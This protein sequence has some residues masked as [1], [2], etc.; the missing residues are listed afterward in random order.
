VFVSCTHLCAA[1][2]WSG[3][4]AT[5]LVL[6]ATAECSPPPAADPTTGNELA[7]DRGRLPTGATLD[8]TGRSTPIG[9]FPL[10][11]IVAPGGDRL[12]ALLN[13]H[14]AQGIQVIDVASGRVT[15]T[16]SQPAAF[17]GLAFDAAGYRLYAS[18]GNQDVVYRY[19]WKAGTATL[20][21]SLVLAP[22]APRASGTRYPAGLALSPDDRFLYVA[23]NLADSLAVID[24]ATGA[25]VQR[26]AAGRYPYAVVVAVDG[27]VYVSAWGGHEVRAFERKGNR[28]VLRATIPAGRHPSA[29][30]LNRDGTRLFVT[31]AS[32]DQIAV[33]DT[34]RATVTAQLSD[35]A[36]TGPAEGSTPDALALSPD[37]GRLYV[38]EADNNAI[39]VF[40]LSGE[41]S[42]LPDHLLGRI[43][44]EW[45]PAAVV[46]HNDTLFV[47]N[48]KGRGTGPNPLGPGPGVR[49]RDSLGYT[50]DQTSGTL[51]VV[52][53]AGLDAAGLGALSRRVAH[54]N[55]WDLRAAG[56]PWPH[57]EH[58]IYIIK[59]NRTYDQLFGD[60]SRA[61]G[62]TAL[63]F[64]PR[65]VTPNHHALAERFGIFDRFFVNAEVSADGHNWSTAAY[66]T[67]Y[68]E[69]TVPQVY[70]GRGRSYDFEGTNRNQAVEDDVAEPAAGY[71]WDLAQRRGLSFRNFGEFVLEEGKREGPV[72]AWY[73][74]LKPFLEANTD[75]TF[76][77]FDL[78]VPDQVRADLW[79]HALGDWERDG[80][81]PALQILRLPN[82][83]T[84]GAKAGA[85]T[86]RAYLAD[87]D[88][89]LGRVIEALSRS[90]FWKST[91]VFVLEDDAQDG[92]DHVD[93]HRAPFLLI[94][95]WNRPRVWHRFTNTTDVLATIEAMLS[96]NH[97]SQFDADA[98]PLRGV[99]ASEPDTMPYRA[100]QPEVPLTEKNPPRGPGAEE[101]SHF[102]FRV[103]DLADDD[104]FNRVLWLAIKGD[105][106]YPGPTRLTAAGP[107]RG[108]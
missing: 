67:D 14:R 26:L 28:L 82:D 58:V 50:L 39:A 27:A 36:T 45:Y 42:G 98:R 95:A 24:L 15:Q 29:L 100:F 6:L 77:G 62:D 92:P 59:E 32:T 25:V 103:E 56:A 75:S 60:L 107:R 65:A 96:L 11:L 57:F 93:S 44:V 66:A 90:R 64:F 20:L 46:A 81:M 53:L 74:G 69:K 1:G 18:G 5:L 34:R 30:L 40:E 80:I 12:I 87:N 52:S 101:S 89:A 85:P 33:V 48:A 78:D 88:L 73:R 35:S 37:E 83:H 99:F 70:S 43:P 38:A 63:L 51:S 23:E 84:A 19:D 61:D 10:A 55:G 76:P 79:L 3:R 22:R 54:A 4:F 86:P 91:V 2:R 9:S 104:R 68:T 16:L 108:D 106:P 31:S 105:T 47:A 97:L 13:G 8:P 49:A 102:D 41:T 7:A 71:L 21:D 94:S 17:I 72:P